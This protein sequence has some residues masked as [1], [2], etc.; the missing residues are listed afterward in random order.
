MKRA[1]VMPSWGR[2]RD[3]AVTARAIDIDVWSFSFSRW[4]ARLLFRMGPGMSAPEGKADIDQRRRDVCFVPQADIPC[5]LATPTIARCCPL[6]QL[7]KQAQAMS[8]RVD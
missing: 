2:N 7:L 4:P 3:M 8:D 1:K 6:P 5:P